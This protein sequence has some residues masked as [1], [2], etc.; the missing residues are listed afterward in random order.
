MRPGWQSISQVAWS[1]ILSRD[2][3]VRKKYMKEF[4]DMMSASLGHGK[5]DI[6]REV[7]LIS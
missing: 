2:C 7:A 4:P 3:K 6:V 1:T 5:A